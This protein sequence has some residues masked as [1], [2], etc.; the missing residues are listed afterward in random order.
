MALK[1]NI[2]SFLMQKSMEL[3]QNEKVMPLMM[4]A[5]QLRSQM[6]DKID[7]KVTKIAGSLN[8]AMK[9]DIYK[10]NSDVRGLDNS[11]K[12]LTS[13]IEELQQKLSDYEGKLGKLEKKIKKPAAK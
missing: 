2:R 5:F 1:D 4:K 6:N 7:R 10:T 3:A 8:L 12:G 13:T 11:V 9:D